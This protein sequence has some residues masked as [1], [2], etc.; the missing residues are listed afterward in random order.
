MISLAWAV[1]GILSTKSLSMRRIIAQSHLL[2]S[3]SSWA[4]GPLAGG[5]FAASA[6]STRAPFRRTFGSRDPQPT[7]N[8]T[9]QQPHHSWDRRKVALTVAAGTVAVA[10]AIA[11]ADAGSASRRAHA[12]SS[13]RTPPSAEELS[14]EGAHSIRTS[15]GLEGKLDG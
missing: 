2:A 14:Q 12:E 5:L 6:T 11:I 15:Q 7:T 8:S 3:S 4:S 13:T 10:A 9:S 1:L